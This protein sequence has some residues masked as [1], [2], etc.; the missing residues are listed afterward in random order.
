[1]TVL[2]AG[3]AGTLRDVQHCGMERSKEEERIPEGRSTGKSL[4]T[5]ARGTASPAQS[6]LCKFSLASEEGREDLT[7]KPDWNVGL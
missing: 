7:L 1:M 2:R 6:Q 5:Q 4:L 3:M